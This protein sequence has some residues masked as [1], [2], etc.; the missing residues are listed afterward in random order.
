MDCPTLRTSVCKC[1]LGG[2]LDFQH[3]PST[4][5]CVLKYIMGDIYIYEEPFVSIPSNKFDGMFSNKYW[6]GISQILNFQTKMY[7]WLFC[8]FQNCVVFFQCTFCHRGR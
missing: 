8:A 4:Q 6:L 3:Y 2:C 7:V 5:M 1:H